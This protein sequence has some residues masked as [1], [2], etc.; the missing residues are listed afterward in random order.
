MNWAALIVLLDQRS[1]AEE[2]PVIRFACLIPEHFVTHVGVCRATGE[3]EV[4]ALLQGL[5]FRF[6]AA[7]SLPS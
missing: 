3:D 5:S 1:L 2:P 6:V 4:A 7:R